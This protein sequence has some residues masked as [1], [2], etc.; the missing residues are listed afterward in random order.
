MRQK[1]YREN[2]RNY[3]GRERKGHPP[4]W[5]EI[6]LFFLARDSLK[7]IGSAC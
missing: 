1:K 7:I 5:A 4:D 6:A 2:P 3:R